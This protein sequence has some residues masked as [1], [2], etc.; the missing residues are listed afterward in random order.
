MPKRFTDTNIWDKPWY[1]KLSTT[2]KCAISYIKDRCDNVGV[3]TPSFAL[4]EFVIGTKVNWEALPGRVNGNIIILPN[5]KW[6]LPDFCTFQYG[7]LEEN[8]NNKARL[9]YVNALKKHGLW[10]GH[11]G[12]SE[13]PKE[14]D[15]E[16]EKDLDLDLYL[17]KKEKRR[18]K[19]NTPTGVPEDRTLY[20]SIKQVFL[21]KNRD[22]NFKRECMHI[23]QLEE[24]AKTREQPE[25]FM[26][27]VL[28][29]FW[30]LTNSEDN[31]F[32]DQPFLPSILNSG[33]IWPRVL[34]KLEQAE[35]DGNDSEVDQEIRRLF[36]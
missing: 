6:Y 21:S 5:G 10:K 4:A 22:F 35:K 34:K 20:H 29:L 13:S 26:S 31:I 24:K 8:T 32:K 7:E 15:K 36:K 12:D 2:D 28:E 23:T 9:S 19:N 33:G 1:I 25:I 14:K 18:E 17:D 30:N 3:W 11:R 16:K 27:M